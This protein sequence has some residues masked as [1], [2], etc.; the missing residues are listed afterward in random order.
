MWGVGCEK[1]VEIFL[2]RGLCTSQERRQSLTLP[3]SAPP[4]AQLGPTITAKVDDCVPKPSSTMKKKCQFCTGP[5]VGRHVRTSRSCHQSPTPPRS[6]PPHP[7]EEGTKRGRVW[8]KLS[9]STINEDG[10]CMQLS[11]ITVIIGSSQAASRLVHGRIFSHLEVFA[12]VERGG[13]LRPNRDP[14]RTLEAPW[15]LLTSEEGTTQ[16]V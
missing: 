4:R 7:G 1:R 2:P 8:Y 5:K 14:F 11:I 9:I 15:K 13:R 16:K 3:R 6:A 10:S 12:P